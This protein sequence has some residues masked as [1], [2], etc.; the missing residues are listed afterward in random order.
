MLAKLYRLT[1]ESDFAR[2][3]KSRSSAYEKL[4]GVKVR[5]NHLS[6]SRFGIVVGLKVS[7]KAPERNKIKRR[8]RE[9][10]RKH[11]ND[12]ESGYDVMILGMKQAVGADYSDIETSLLKAFK[13]VKLL[14]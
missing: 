9:I 11:F 5:E 4:L 1:S 14:K 6:H 10:I 3:A 13:K 7:K 8:I 2:V 12:L